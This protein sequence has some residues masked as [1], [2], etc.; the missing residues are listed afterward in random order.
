MMR[1]GMLLVEVLVV[2]SC[3]S[4]LL[5]VVMT[6]FV[7]VS[8]QGS[9]PG[10]FISQPSGLLAL[11]R[12]FRDDVHCGLSI[13]AS[14]DGSAMTILCSD[15]RA[16][17]YRV[18]AHSVL[19]EVSAGGSIATREAWRR[20]GKSRISFETTTAASR[21]V[22]NLIVHR[23]PIGGVGALTFDVGIVA[24]PRPELVIEAD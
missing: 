12:R 9:A 1:R 15:G 24:V 17:Q 23:S 8:E 4:V 18:T 11:A 22:A 13:S 14:N 21:P 5:A 19:R 10:D 2:M 6:I 16:I 3:T 20:H 7:V